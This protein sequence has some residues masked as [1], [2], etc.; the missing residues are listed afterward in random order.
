MQPSFYAPQPALSGLVNN[1]MISHI[2]T[3]VK[4]KR[5]SFPFPPLPE[6][7]IFFYPFDRPANENTVTKKVYEHPRCL[8]VGP[9]TERLNLT[10]GYDHLVIKI[11][12]QPGGL[13]RLLGIPM[14]EML[15]HKEFDGED[16]FGAEINDTIDA[17]ANAAGHIEMKTI[18]E[19][20]L[21]RQATKLKRPAPIDFVLREILK[22]SGLAKID[23]LAKQACMSNR[24]F[25][26]VFKERMG[27]SPKFYSRHVRF[28][29]AW[30]MKENN[31]AVTWTEIAYKCGYFD[32]M[33]MIRDFQAFAGANPQI[34]AE[35]LKNQP[36]SLDNRIFY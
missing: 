22:Y 5:L 28:A 1:I 27:L 8:V 17:L 19:A 26:R 7:C 31:P 6:H 16:I 24:Q 33:H 23:R 34:I 18:A 15:R 2:R 20:F 25:E 21:I 10:F 30:L 13:Y 36:F 3:D 12:F 14:E 32:Q 4:H 11:G 35:A 29:K 9:N